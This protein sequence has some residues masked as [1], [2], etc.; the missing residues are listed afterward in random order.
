MDDDDDMMMVFRKHRDEIH[1]SGFLLD[2]GAGGWDW[3]DAHRG[4]FLT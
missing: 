1:I 3:K 4:C 2:E